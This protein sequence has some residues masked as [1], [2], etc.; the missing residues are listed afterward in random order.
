MHK[1]K[2]RDR[3]E[4]KIKGIGKQRTS[5]STINPNNKSWYDCGASY[6]TRHETKWGGGLILS[7]PSIEL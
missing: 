2:L 4:D 5:Y 1:S 6:D 7:I 3:K